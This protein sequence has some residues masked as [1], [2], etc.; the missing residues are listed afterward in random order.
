MLK[1]GIVCWSEWQATTKTI[2]MLLMTSKVRILFFK[3]MTF[4]E[5]LLLLVQLNTIAGKRKS[6]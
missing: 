5:S 4:P 3:I 6:S 2:A 1:A